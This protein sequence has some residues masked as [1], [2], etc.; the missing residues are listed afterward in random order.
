MNGLPPPMLLV[1]PPL[2]MMP[3]GVGPSFPQ[4][5]PMPPP[6]MPAPPQPFQLPPPPPQPSW[7]GKSHF[8]NQ[9]PSGVDLF[10]SEQYCNAVQQ[11]GTP[12]A[13]L[14]AMSP[15]NHL[16]V[17]KTHKKQRI[18][19]SRC[20]ADIHG[21]G[22]C[23]QLIKWKPHFFELCDNHRDWTGMPC[24][25]LKLPIEIRMH[26]FS[27]LL[28]DRPVSAWLDRSLK[29][30]G[31]KCTASVLLVNRQIHEEAS[32]VLYRTQPFTVSIQRNTLNMCGRAYYH[33]LSG[34][35]LTTPSPSTGRQPVR[36]PMLDKI[37]SIRIQMTMVKPSTRLNRRHRTRTSWD[38]EVE[39]YDLRDSVQCFYHMLQSRNTLHSLSV[40]F[41]TQNQL[42][43][44]DDDQQFEYLKLAMD[45]MRGLRNIL[46]VDLK[47]IYQ[48]TDQL[49]MN[50]TQYIL[51]HL[52]P[53]QRFTPPPPPG[54]TPT[55][56]TTPT[57]PNENEFSLT[58]CF[59]TY[60]MVTA[61]TP[62]LDV[63]RRLHDHA[64]FLSFK[65]GWESEIRSSA[66]SP[67]LQRAA[68]SAFKSFRAVYNTVDGHYFTRLPKGN[69]WMLHQARVAREKGDIQA[70]RDLRV[71]LE[72][73][74]QEYIEMDRQS[75]QRKEACLAAGFK[76]YDDQFAKG[77]DGSS[78]QSEAGFDSD[79]SIEA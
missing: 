33:D 6:A 50:T 25:L 37:K 75:F 52:C 48:C 54:G 42:D 57:T 74:V 49:R 16:P 79:S 51:D 41:C 30:D 70:I 38:E 62:L 13:R 11:N 66:P 14:A 10:A 39:V 28:P 68:R 31:F 67:P 5:P 61:Q 73:K 7:R 55:E 77:D 47:C 2:G 46:Q 20:K 40:V 17:C 71:E 32:K 29:S 72:S 44:W 45:P 76:K 36:P 18:R 35:Q 22:L 12:C 43:D 63:S 78:S 21:R 58:N 34:S 24:H 9:R 15:K 64:G 69:K 65:A 27:Y 59:D 4:P 53:R 26:I 56:T 60:G 19:F 23:Q 3:A 1:P 8:V